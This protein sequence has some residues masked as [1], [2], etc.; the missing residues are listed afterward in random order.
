MRYSVAMKFLAVILCAATLL[1]AAGSAVGM[2]ALAEQGLYDRSVEEAYQEYLESVSGS[3]AQMVGGRYVSETLGGADRWMLNDHYG[4]NWWY[5]YFDPDRMGYTLKDGEGNV[6]Q[7]RE[8]GENYVPA[9]TFEI[10]IG[11]TYMKVLSVT[12]EDAYK[13]TEP[14]PT[15]PVIANVMVMPTQEI[16]PVYRV[17]LD[18]TDRSGTV[19]ETGEELGTLFFEG[20]FLMFESNEIG[21]IPMGDGWYVNHILL[22]DAAGNVVYEASDRNVIQGMEMDGNFLR[23]HLPV[24]QVT[25][26]APAGISFTSGDYTSYDAIPVQG[27]TVAQMNVTYGDETGDAGSEGV[28]SPDLIGTLFHDYQGNAE[29]HSTEP[30]TMDIPENSILTRITFMDGEG[31]VIFEAACP[32]GVGKLHNDE[33]GYLVFRGTMPGTAVPEETAPEETL[34]EESTGPSMAIFCTAGEDIPVYALPVAGGEPVATLMAGEQAVI[35]QTGYIGGANWALIEQGWILLDQT[36][37]QRTAEPPLAE[38]AAAAGEPAPAAENLPGVPAVSAENTA[39]PEETVPEVTEVPEETLPAMAEETIPAATEETISAVTEETLPQETYGSEEISVYAY[40]DS[41]LQQSMVAEYVME[42]IP[43]G[44]TM[45]IQLAS[46]ASNYEHEWV[47]MR[48][49]Y[50]MKNYLPQILGISLLLWA[51]SAVYLCCAAGRRRGTNAVCAGGLNRVPLDLYLG[52]GALAGAGLVVLGVEGTGYLMRSNIQIG[53]LFLLGVAFA[54][55][56]LVVG[57]GFAFVAQIKTPGGFWWRNSCIGFSLKYIWKFCIWLE[58]VCVQLW[59]KGIPLLGRLLGWLWGVT[60]A[61]VQVGIKAALWLWDMA[62]KLLRLCWKWV[63]LA[64]HWGTGKFL[65]FFSLLPLTWQFLLTGFV[66]V[67]ILYIMMRTYKVGYILLGFG[68]FF[69]VLL[70]AASAFAILLESAKHM[71]HGDLDTKVDD[72]LLIGCF[73]DFAAELNEL[74]DVAMVAAQKQ[75]KS[76][77]MKTE[78]ITNVS[79]DIKTPLTSIIN[80]VDLMEKPHTPEEQAAYLEVLARQAQRLK[81]LIDDLMEMS[82][83]STGNMT[84]DI[85]RVNA[86]ETVNQALGEFA[87]K[88]E[89]AQVIPV[90]RHPEKEM[91]M[92]ADGR[93]VWRVLS[94]LLGNAV[95]YAMPGT[96]MYLDLMEMDGKVILSIKNI[97]RE[98]LNVSADELLERFVR[99]DASRNTEGSGLGLNIAQSLMELQKG[100]LQLLVD[101]DLFKVTLIF[102]GV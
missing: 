47:L 86:V 49:V 63:K 31:N 11:G 101:G 9:H 96:R 98:P 5:S 67:F 33:N 71:S 6:L 24:G 20:A 46:G 8:M 70:Y 38:D 56:L 61:L 89:R 39:L 73:R 13:G 102:P 29:F 74:A 97:S 23:L 35:L 87:D 50:A 7:S 48:T 28:A 16:T 44:F 93:L 40:Y 88:L 83:A 80:Y 59:K 57:F 53:L 100:Q 51:I 54:A 27:T 2:F 66:I 12:P 69:G 77:R 1:G 95:K 15:E 19:Y 79:H 99:G 84:V 30:M 72:R 34:P 36:M 43:A 52:G 65:R 58:K 22:E 25:E 91:E 4:G 32:G 82:K 62:G 14:A 76:E 26:T 55:S 45:E 92:M 18:Y 41:T 81:K 60:L 85:S 3:Y 37:M 68:I 10:P 75:M 21:E 42:P 64:W 90:F 94:N 17:I 78:L